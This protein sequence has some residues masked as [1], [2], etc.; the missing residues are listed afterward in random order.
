METDSA[1]LHDFSPLFRQ[2]KSGRVERFSG[3]TT[4]FPSP[5]DP[6]TGV[7]SKLAVIDP[8]TP[9]SACLY[10]PPN[11]PS[12]SKLPVLLYFHG[13]AFCIESA[14]S[15]TYHP[16]LTSLASRALLLIV[17]VDYRLAPEHPL[18]AAYD[19]CWSAVKWVFS[20][21]D[22]CLA[23]FGDLRQV[24]LAGDSAGANIAHRMAV[25]AGLEGLG[26]A[27]IALV[28]PYFWGSEAVGSEGREESWR[29]WM[30]GLWRAVSGGG[31]GMD[32]AWINPA[33]EGE[34]AVARLGCRRVLVCVAER[35]PMRERGRAYWEM[36]KGSGW[37]GEVEIVETEGEGHVFHLEKT[38]GDGKVRELMDDLVRFFTKDREKGWEGDRLP[39]D[40]A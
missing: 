3:T 12:N 10:L 6:T 2:Y 20:R 8:F 18:P 40:C 5:L 14:F 29:A 21:A 24:F 37:R 26:F 35:D 30:D 4:V 1:I 19:D 23:R 31:K 28:H 15:Q 36:L 7:S 25:R 39:D 9:V 38:E 22:P 16:H 34:E 17:S 13:G 27:G 33:A 11:P 32:D